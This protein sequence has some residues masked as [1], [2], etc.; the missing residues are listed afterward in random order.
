MNVED[1]IEMEE[2]E[3]NSVRHL[4]DQLV[5]EDVTLSDPDGSKKADRA[6]IEV[7][8]WMKF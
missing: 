8:K 5:V 1:G 3:W 6:M 2:K 7:V 4:D